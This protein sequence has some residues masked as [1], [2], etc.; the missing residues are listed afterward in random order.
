[1]IVTCQYHCGECHSHFASLKAFDAHRAGTHH[2]GTRHCLDPFDVESLV[3]KSDE[4]ECRVY[5][6]IRRGE[7]VWADKTDM[8]R[9]KGLR[10]GLR[11]A[12]RR[13]ESASGQAA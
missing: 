11:L 1:M 6:P 13:A 7:I 4:A 5:V 8:E 10:A 3:E 12:A 2:K 9:G